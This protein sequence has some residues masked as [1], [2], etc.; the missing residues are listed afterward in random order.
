MGGAAG[1]GAEGRTEAEVEPETGATTAAGGSGAPFSSADF[2][3]SV[4]FGS[5]SLAAS[6]TSA[7]QSAA[8]S[9]LSSSGGGGT[10]A[11]HSIGLA[12]RSAGF[13][14]STVNEACEAASCA[15][16][17]EDS[18]IVELCPACSS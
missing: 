7:L 1:G 2:R 16:N 17:G 8:A 10:E 12:A 4:S 13:P 11:I 6:A 14:G 9:G 18:T 3:L 15:I 5:I